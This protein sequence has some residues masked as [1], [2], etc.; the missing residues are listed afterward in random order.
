MPSAVVPLFDGYAERPTQ[1]DQD[2]DDDD[3]RH[4]AEEAARQVAP[5]AAHL[6][7]VVGD[8]LETRVREHRERQGEGDVVPA[9]MRAEREV[10]A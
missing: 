1:R 6:F 10:R 9:R 2:V 3:E 8:R 5:R 7:G 4:R